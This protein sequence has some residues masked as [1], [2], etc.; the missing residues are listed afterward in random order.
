M[1]ENISRFR[2]APGSRD[3]FHNEG[4]ENLFKIKKYLTGPKGAGILFVTPFIVIFLVFFLYPVIS[5]VQMSFQSILPGQVK[6]VGLSNYTT[7]FHDKTYGLSILNSLQYLVMSA[8]V[9]IPVPLALALM[10]NAKNM[11]WRN[12]FKSSLFIPALVSV[13][14]AGT[15]FRL[16]FGDTPT[17]LMN[18]IRGFFGLQPLRWKNVRWSAYSV[19]V[20][21]AL[22]RWC[23]V[24]IVYF[25]SGLQNIPEELYEAASIDGA[26]YWQSLFSITIPLLKPTLIYVLT[27]VLYGGVAMFNE[28]YMLYGDY[29]SPMNVGTTMA[30]YLYRQAFALNKI[31]YAS[32][33]GLMSLIFAFSINLIQL[34]R[35]GLFEKGE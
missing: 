25:Y 30:V 8:V 13:V 9:L 23:G 15:V 27:L 21:M 29:N 20:I 18:S 11:P 16:M 22:W 34:R 6:F 3:H 2:H 17:A 10:L 24:Y 26:S 19:M 4:V 28:S 33:V 5:L 14:V 12:F 35:F 32:C 1:K 7:L 31:G